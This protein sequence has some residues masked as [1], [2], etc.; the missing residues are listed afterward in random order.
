MPIT[1]SMRAD[2]GPIPAIQFARLSGFSTIVA[3]A[4]LHNSELLKGLGATHVLDRKLS[5][6]ALRAESTK[7]ASGL[8]DIAYD[9]VSVPETLPIS[10][11]LTKPN[12]DLVTLLPPGNVQEGDEA[13]GKKVHMASAFFVIPTN[14]EICVSLLDSLPRLLEAGDIKVRLLLLLTPVILSECVNSLY[15]PKYFLMDC[16]AFLLG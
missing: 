16:T 12:G 7:I 15:A 8:F 1:I 6:D 11:S 13:S 14:H 4:S 5:A 10:Y 2:F 9:A 3:V